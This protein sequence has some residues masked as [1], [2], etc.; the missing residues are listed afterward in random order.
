MDLV[1]FSEAIDDLALGAEAIWLPATIRLGKLNPK[2]KMFGWE[3]FQ[4]PSTGGF[5]WWHKESSDALIVE[6]CPSNGWQIV[7]FNLEAPSTLDCTG[8]HVGEKDA[9]LHLAT[10]RW[11]GQT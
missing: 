4:N 7:K 1:F 11:F 8:T 3:V 10:G 6:A 5:W 2:K 9:Y